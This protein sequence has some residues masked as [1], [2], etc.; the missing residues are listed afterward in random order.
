[1]IKKILQYL[2]NKDRNRKTNGIS[3]KKG[4]L[5]IIGLVGILLLLFGNLFQST[6]E[7]PK[8]ENIDLPIEKKAKDTTKDTTS[9]SDVNELEESYQNDLQEM[10]EKIQGVSDVEVMVNLDS[11]NVHVYEKNLIVGQQTTDEN[12]KSG[13]TRKIEEHTEE[14]QVVLVRQGDQ[15]TPLLIHTK[16]PDVRGVFVVAKGVDHASVKEW[17]IEAVSRVLDVPTH[18]VSVMPKN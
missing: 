5:L 17:V 18:R 2:S 1:M 6:E 16:K 9:T 11:T 13:G 4:Y 12:D 15:E 7:A 14:T 8:K 3:K 10:L